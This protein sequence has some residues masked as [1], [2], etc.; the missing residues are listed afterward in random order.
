MESQRKDITD[1][2]A[3]IKVL[4]NHGAHELHTMNLPSTHPSYHVVSRRSQYPSAA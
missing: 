4:Q 2:I 3:C 1:I